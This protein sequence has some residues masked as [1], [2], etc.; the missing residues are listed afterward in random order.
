MAQF[1]LRQLGLGY[2]LCSE[3]EVE[4]ADVQQPQHLEFS[5]DNHVSDNTVLTRRAKKIFSILVFKREYLRHNI[6]VTELNSYSRNLFLL[7]LY[8]S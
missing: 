6:V 2:P 8:F 4:N 5:D 1:N 3:T 7:R